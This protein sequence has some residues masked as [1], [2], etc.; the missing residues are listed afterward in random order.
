MKI[1]PRTWEF[2]GDFCCW[3]FQWRAESEEYGPS[4]P[5]STN[6]E[7]VFFGGT[8]IT[9]CPFCGKKIVLEKDMKED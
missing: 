8:S 5:I 3:E 1:K 6:G 7:K 2:V 9:N 4:P